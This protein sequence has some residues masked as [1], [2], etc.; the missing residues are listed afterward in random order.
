MKLHQATPRRSIGRKTAPRADATRSLM[1]RVGMINRIQSAL[2][3]SL[4]AEDVHSIILATLISREGF[5]FSRSLLLTYEEGPGLL[6]GLAALGATDARQHQRREEKSLAHMVRDLNE[7]KGETDEEE[8]IFKRSLQDLSSHSFWI[9]TYQVYSGAGQLQE[10]LRR[11]ELPCAGPGEDDG[12]PT[13]RLLR[14]V[15]DSPNALLVPRQRL[16]AASPPRALADLLPGD[17]LWR[18][19]RT[20]KGLRL[21]VIADK[22]FRQ[23]EPTPQPLD[24]LHLDWLAG[25][26]AMG[27]Q[28]AEMYQDLEQTYRELQDLDRIKSNFL[29]TVSHEL[30]TPLTAIVGYLQLLLGNKLGPISPGQREA[31][32]RISEQGDQLTGKVNDLIEI[33]EL[34]MGDEVEMQLEPIDP[35][36]ALIAVLPRVE[37]RRTRKRM[38]IEPVVDHAIPLIRGNAR[39]LERIFFHLLD[40]GLKFGREGE[41]VR[42]EFHE[43]DG[44]LAIAVHDDGIGIPSQQM[45]NI[46]DAFYQVDNQLTRRYAGLGIGLTLIKRQLDLTGGRIRVESEPARG[47]T[48]TILYP[49]A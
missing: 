12:S 46:F 9:T 29:A 27:L 31:L 26:A 49:L 16:A 1:E 10:A 39:A 4:N 36:G 8:A 24:A 44:L 17:S 7:L 32:E 47:S 28:I 5:D 11:V 43:Q 40:N 20:Q 25:Q 45:R 14:A 41:N 35:L 2:R 22:L 33:A 13:G 19:I 30:R 3:S 23:D 48:F 18:A 34:D 6:R 21:I 15:I 38:T 42:V 37:A